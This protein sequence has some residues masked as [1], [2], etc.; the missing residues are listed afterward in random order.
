MKILVLG[1]NGFI[2]SHVVDELLDAGHE[3]RVFGRRHEVWRKPL[4]SVNYFLGDFSNVPLLAEALQG[5]D[6]VVHLISTTVPST[7]NLDPISDIQ[8][9][10]ESSVRLFQVMVSVNVKRIIFLSSGG[11]VYGIPTLIPV[12]EDHP[13]NPICSYGVVKV[14]VENYLG[15]FE[16]LY[17]LKPLIIRASNPFGPRQGH[18]GVQ[19][20]A[21]TFMQKALSGEKVTIWGDGTTKRDYLYV[22]DLAKICRMATESELTGI[23]N[24]GSGTG[25]TLVELAHMIERVSGMKLNMEYK[26]GRLFD[27]REIVLNIDKARNVLNWEPEITIQDGLKLLFDWMANTHKVSAERYNQ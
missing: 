2:G 17:G 14:A 22:T 23:F 13:L 9:N 11:T 26:A 1:G 15:M 6:L 25:L 21:S 10:L 27:V 12:Q 4:P 7:S 5:V 24:A 16:K 3:V 20:V 19:G 8:G 18:D